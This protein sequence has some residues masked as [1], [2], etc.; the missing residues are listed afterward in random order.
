MTVLS[1]VLENM[2][3]KIKSLTFCVSKCV[4]WAVCSP[5]S[6]LRSRSQGSAKQF[7]VLCRWWSWDLEENLANMRRLRTTQGLTWEQGVTWAVALP[8]TRAAV[9]CLWSS[10]G[11]STHAPEWPSQKTALCAVR[12]V[13]GLCRTRATC[14]QEALDQDVKALRCEY[15]NW[16]GVQYHHIV[17]CETNPKLL[18]TRK[19]VSWEKSST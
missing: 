7:D 15:P 5:L 10:T 18:K 16:H 1:C 9:P 6:G 12:H 8:D 19:L 3:S 17:L 11:V 2:L 4:S 14:E 13:H